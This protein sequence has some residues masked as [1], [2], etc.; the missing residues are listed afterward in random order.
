MFTLSEPFLDQVA[1]C[2]IDNRLY[3]ENK[4]KRPNC[5]LPV[6]DLIEQLKVNLKMIDKDLF[7]KLRDGD[8]TFDQVRARLQH[9]NFNNNYR[10]LDDFRHDLYDQK[11]AEPNLKNEQ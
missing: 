5:R 2:L 3:E 10:I 4:A 8:L 11:I 7:I 9:K 1:R 6:A